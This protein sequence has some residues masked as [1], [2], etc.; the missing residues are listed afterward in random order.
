MNSLHVFTLTVAIGLSLPLHTQSLRKGNA[1]KPE[2]AKR[3]LAEIQQTIP[4]LASWEILH[5]CTD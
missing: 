3:E 4:D 1:M 5:T 2:Q